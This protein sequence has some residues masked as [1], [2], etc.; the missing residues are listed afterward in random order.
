MDSWEFEDHL[1][2]IVFKPKRN[3][4]IDLWQREVRP[5][6]VPHNHRLM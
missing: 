1:D 5:S 6:N 3:N 4:F 2:R